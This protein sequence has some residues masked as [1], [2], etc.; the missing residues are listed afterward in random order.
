MAVGQPLFDIDDR[1]FSNARD[2]ARAEIA[3]QEAE[4]AELESEVARNDKLLPSGA[5]TREQA[6]I[7]AAKRDMAA[8]TLDKDRA[9][10]AQSELDLEFCRIAAPLAGRIGA[11]TVSVGD[12]VGGGAAPTTLATIVSVDPVYVTFFADES[13]LLRARERAIEDRRLEGGQIGRA[14]V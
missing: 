3:R 2:Q 7:V 11:R 4:V 1:S 14:H 5:V 8:A 13:S 12:L 9:L 10:L 6:G